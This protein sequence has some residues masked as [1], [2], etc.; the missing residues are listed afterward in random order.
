MTFLHADIAARIKQYQVAA[1][2]QGG[3]PQGCPAERGQP[4]PVGLIPRN[5]Y[6]M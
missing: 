4:D 1:G 6:M 5:P 2:Q 3:Y